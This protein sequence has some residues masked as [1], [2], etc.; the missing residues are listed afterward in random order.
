[1]VKKA[2]VIEQQTEFFGGDDPCS[3]LRNLSAYSMP[4]AA[5]ARRIRDIE[6]EAGKKNAD[7]AIAKWA[8]EVALRLAF[9][10]DPV[11]PFEIEVHLATECRRR[12]GAP[13]G[14]KNACSVK[15]GK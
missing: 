3:H 4:C 9:Q 7:A 12:G 13:R 6:A 2:D 11:D 8:R 14:N 1:M 5:M 10:D 15:G